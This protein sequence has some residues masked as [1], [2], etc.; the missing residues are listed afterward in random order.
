MY[1]EGLGTAKNAQVAY[2]WIFAASLQGDMRGVGT[3][4]VL[5]REFSADQLTE[6]KRRAESLAQVGRSRGESRVALLR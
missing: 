5:E 1:M 6:S 3:L 2:E 4:R